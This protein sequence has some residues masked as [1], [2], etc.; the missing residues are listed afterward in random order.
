MTKDL[1]GNTDA[2]L[3]NKIMNDEYMHSAV[4]GCYETLN[5]ILMGLLEDGG[6]KM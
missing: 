3:I 4:V 5:D 6:D 2:E 1:K